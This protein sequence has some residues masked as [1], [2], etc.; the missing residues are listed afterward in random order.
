MKEFDGVGRSKNHNLSI[1]KINSTPTSSL[2]SPNLSCWCMFFKN[3]VPKY[4][5][6]FMLLVVAFQK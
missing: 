5:R 2:R 1:L 3:N 4:K 6:L